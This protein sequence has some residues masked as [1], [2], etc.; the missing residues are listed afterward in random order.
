M[1][2]QLRFEKI[3]VWRGCI[4][5][6]CFSI[7]MTISTLLSYPCTIPETIV[8][9]LW[10][11]LALLY[12]HTLCAFLFNL[13]FSSR[14]LK[15]PSLTPLTPHLHLPLSSSLLTPHPLQ[16]TLWPPHICYESSIFPWQNRWLLCFHL[17]SE[18]A[19]WKES[20]YLR[21]LHRLGRYVLCCSYRK[22]DLVWLEFLG[23][24]GKSELVWVV[25]PF[26]TSPKQ[27]AASLE[28]SRN[29]ASTVDS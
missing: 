12:F 19:L 29:K 24:M 14:F 16:P 4:K 18:L 2:M 1:V 25:T 15:F 6:L 10:L 8:S 17:L 26:L 7:H 13:S 27:H 11:F 21:G 9:P 3:F 23:P 22:K 28:N 20:L 5:N